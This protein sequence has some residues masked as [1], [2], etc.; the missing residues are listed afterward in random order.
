LSDRLSNR[1]G[2][3]HLLSAAIVRLAVVAALVCAMGLANPRRAAGQESFYRGKTVI[4][5]AGVAP[6]GSF[7]LYA[8]LVA[9]HLGDHIA[10]RPTIIVENKS[11]AGG[12]TA[13]SYLC[14][15]APPDGTV[16]E[17]V[18]PAIALT[19]ALK[20]ADAPCDVRALNWIGRLTPINEVFY[21]WHTSPTKTLADLQR[22][23]TLTAGTGP[24][25]G[26]T[27]LTTLLNDLVGTK[28]KLI[29]GY[30]ETAA[31]MLAVERGEV[32]GVI[33]PWEGMK[34]GR[35]QAWLGHGDINLV[36][37]FAIER[38]PELPRV[39]A[40][41]EL[42]KTDRQREILRFFLSPNDIGRSFTLGPGVPAPRVAIMRTAFAGMVR[43]PQFLA[44]AAKL[45]MNLNPASANELAKRSAETLDAPPDVVATARRYYPR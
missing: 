1:P 19:Q 40:V 22:R 34:A 7:D 42:L 32:E 17:I 6:G 3:D 4:I 39:G 27:I 10:G 29:N 45:K 9:R 25:A 16:L 28:F 41:G 14:K 31:A 30:N 26:S 35:E 20:P 21:T 18:P 15:V 2:R 12:L 43:D 5:L 11:G 23:Q 37:Q 36:A 24:D 44:D 38:S 13:F 33:R 8:R